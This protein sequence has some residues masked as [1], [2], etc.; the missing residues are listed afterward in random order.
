MRGWFWQGSG[1]TQDLRSARFGLGALGLRTVPAA[2]PVEAASLRP[3]AAPDWLTDIAT[4][5]FFESE[6]KV[7]KREEGDEDGTDLLDL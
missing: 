2:W 6:R 1:A 5:R 7:N 4:A 3:C